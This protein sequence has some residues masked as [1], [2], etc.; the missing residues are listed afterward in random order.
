MN[1]GTVELLEII[2][3]VS[4][5]LYVWLTARANIWCWA[6]GLVNVIAYAVV[7]FSTKLYADAILQIIYFILTVYGWHSWLRGDSQRQERRITY[8]QV[9]ELWFL[10]GAAGILWAFVWCILHFFTDGAFVWADSFLMSASMAA[11]W[12]TARKY[13]QSWKLWIAIDILYIPLYIN[14]NLVPTALLYL[15]FAALAWI[16]LKSWQKIMLQS[17]VETVAC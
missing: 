16:G 5:L 7:F 8:A 2:G 15:L 11:T 6:T 12:M 3:V 10:M 4:G 13:L 9:K 17:T 14:K 1:I